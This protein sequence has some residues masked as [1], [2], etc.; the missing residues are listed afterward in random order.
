MG[1]NK[2]YVENRRKQDYN[3]SDTLAL[4]I[5]VE[6]CYREVKIKEEETIEEKLRIIRTIEEGN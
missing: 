2:S 4:L 3:Y 5:M 1:K 6:W